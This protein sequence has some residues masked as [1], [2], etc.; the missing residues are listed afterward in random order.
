MTSPTADRRRPEGRYDPP[1][2]LVGRTFAVV[3]SVLFIGLLGAIAYYLYDRYGSDRVRARVIDF[4]VLSDTSVRIDV[5]VLKRE[6]GQAYCLVRSRGSSGAEV[7]RDVV[8][9]D[10]VGTAER[11][12]RVEHELTTSER[13][14]TGEV[15]RCTDVPIPMPARSP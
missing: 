4:Q 2:Q 14:V 8:V 7:G 3:L 15:G 10:A 13:A 6:G 9:V 11:V 12:V 5:E 1:S